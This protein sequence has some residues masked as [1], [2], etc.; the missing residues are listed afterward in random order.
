MID[1]FEIETPHTFSNY[2]DISSRP[3]FTPEVDTSSTQIEKLIATYSFADKHPC[4]KKDCHQPHNNGWLAV[5]TDKKET[6]IGSKCGQLW[7]GDAF[8]L[9]KNQLSKRIKRDSQLKFL[10]E[11]LRNAEST[12]D[13]VQ[14]I[15]TRSNG[16]IWLDKAISK[17]QNECSQNLMRTL[18]SKANR[19]ETAV[20]KSELKS[21]DERDLEMAAN[22]NTTISPYKSVLVGHLVGLDTFSTD[23]REVLMIGIHSKLQALQKV[24][25]S[26]LPTPLLNKW[27]KDVGD[28]ENLFNQAE[29]IIK[30][31]NLFF[32]TKN[33]FKLLNTLD[34]DRKHGH[35]SSINW[36]GLT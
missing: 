2:A 17:L 10:H 28:F 36:Q 6:L 8:L 11:I 18:R 19:G 32:S 27:S 5:T 7:G 25:L 31:G 12:F 15:K 16:A 26:T 22:P 13:R 35:L 9:Q 24:D 29:A 14:D 1:D 21:Q 33:N 23:L 4:G 3:R 20:E 30:N 34:T